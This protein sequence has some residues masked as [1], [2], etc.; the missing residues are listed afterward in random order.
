MVGT[1][2]RVEDHALFD[3]SGFYREDRLVLTHRGYQNGGEAVYILDYFH[4]PG[5]YAGYVIAEDSKLGGPEY[6]VVQCPV[7][8]ILGDQ[9]NASFTSPADVAKDIPY[10]RTKCIEFK[11]V[12]TLREVVEKGQES[13]DQLLSG[14]PKYVEGRARRGDP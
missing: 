9:P 1:K 14:K 8:M 12:P 3:V 2:E 4:D 6:W 10:M 11:M 5:V 13:I 7:M